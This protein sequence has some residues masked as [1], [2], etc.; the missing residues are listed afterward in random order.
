MPTRIDLINGV[1]NLSN[2]KVENSVIFI[3]G[4]VL[5]KSAYQYLDELISSINNQDTDDFSVLFINDDIDENEIKN[6]IEGLKRQYEI[7]KYNEILSPIE[8]RIKLIEEAKSRSADWL[9]MCDADDTL[10]N[11]R[12]SCVS[13]VAS[14]NPDYCFLYNDIVDF[15]GNEML[16]NMPAKVQNILD[17]IDYNFLGLSN[18]A[19]YVSLISE[20]EILDLHNCQQ[21]VFDWYLYSI[22]LLNNK[23][24]LYVPD[25]KTFY[26]IHDN[27]IIGNQDINPQKIEYEV[28]VKIKHYDS[29]KRKDAELLKRF[30]KYCNGSY[31]V[32]PMTKKVYWWGYT[33]PT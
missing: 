10:S 18:T 15:S 6:K 24:G 16:P 30:H 1:S 26:R 2:I 27:N 12:I 9:I 3:L 25:V 33:Y 31:G 28:S 8:L 20:N 13:K 21:M 19:L 22:L 11:N 7:I 17:I 4:I 5:Y 23:K 32:N 29:L 14:N